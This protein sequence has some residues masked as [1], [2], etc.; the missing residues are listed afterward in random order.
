[1]WIPR[2]TTKTQG[3]E[4]NAI[5]FKR[6]QRGI[7]NIWCKQRRYAFSQGFQA[8]LEEAVRLGT[9]RCLQGFLLDVSTHSSHMGHS[10]LF[11]FGN[12]LAMDREP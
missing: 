4:T 5:F 7:K 9:P 10:V 8:V 11:H 1:M 2:A 3:S 12:K 6:Q